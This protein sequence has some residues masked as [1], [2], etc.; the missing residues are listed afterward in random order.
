MVYILLTFP[1]SHCLSDYFC[2][3]LYIC[4]SACLHFF[5]L[6]CSSCSLCLSICIMCIALYYAMAAYSVFLSSS[7][8]LCLCFSISIDFSLYLSL[9]FCLCL[10]VFAYLSLSFCFCRFLSLPVTVFFIHKFL[11]L[12][13]SLSMLFYLLSWLC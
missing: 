4:I 5:V 8:T 10:S 3:I 6:L 13:P 12:Y 11:W 7:L 2:S 9:Y 1:V